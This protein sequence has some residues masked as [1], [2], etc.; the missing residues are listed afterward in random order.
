MTETTN[1]KPAPAGPTDL[2]MRCLARFTEGMR[3]ADNLTLT[4]EAERLEALPTS[5]AV[6]EMRRIVA[7]EQDTRRAGLN[8]TR[9]VPPAGSDASRLPA[10]ATA[11]PLGVAA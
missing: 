4:H 8:P 7:A 5:P 2:M 11:I 3:A 1:I 6:T 10:P 9:R